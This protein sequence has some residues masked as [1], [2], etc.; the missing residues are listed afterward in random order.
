MSQKTRAIKKIR[1]VVNQRREALKKEA[2]NQIALEIL[3]LPFWQRVKL[4]W[5]IVWRA[6]SF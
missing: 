6:K 2:I 5:R 3:T 4:A 1:R